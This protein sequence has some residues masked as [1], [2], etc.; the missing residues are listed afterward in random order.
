MNKKATNIF[1]YIISAAVAGVLL[2]FSF[3]EVKWEDFIKGLESCRW[4][5]IIMSMAAGIAAFWFR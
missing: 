1:K 4:E 5:Y 2:Y 3:R